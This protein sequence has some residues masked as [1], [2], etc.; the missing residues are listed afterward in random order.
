[1]LVHHESA[2]R[3]TFITR[4]KQERYEA[5]R[6]AMVERWGERLASDPHYNPNLS[7]RPEDKPF[8]LAFL[9]RQVMNHD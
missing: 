3:G 8:S 6:G 9:P 2:S 1:V 7:I 4:A 5:A